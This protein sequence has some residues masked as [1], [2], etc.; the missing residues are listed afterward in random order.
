LAGYLMAASPLPLPPPQVP[1][2]T[3]GGLL[4]QPGFEFL[5]RLQA[6]V[7]QLNTASLTGVITPVQLT[8]DQNDYNPAGLATASIMRLTSDV[9]VRHITGIAA[10]SD[11]RLMQLFNCNAVGGASIVVDTESGSSSPVNRFISGVTI[12]AGNGRTAW[13]DAISSR[14]RFLV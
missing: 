1:F 11:G 4:T 3:P 9:T 2:V 12:L 8:A 5:D 7:K 6:L 14:W 10:Q 13:Y